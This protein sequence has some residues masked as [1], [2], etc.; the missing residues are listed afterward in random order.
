[1]LGLLGLMGLVAA[2][3]ALDAMLGGAGDED[4]P[5]A[6]PEDGAPD[7]AEAFDRDPALTDASLIPNGYG[8]AA[9]QPV[10]DPAEAGMPTS[11]DRP[12]AAEAA[13]EREGT[14]GD[15]RLNGAGG[16]DTL[17]GLDGRDTLEGWDGDDT[18]AGGRGDDSLNGGSGHDRLL[19]GAGQDVLVGGSGDDSLTGGGGNDELDG[20]EGNDLLVGGAGD[21]TLN[22]G[23][24]DDRLYAGTGG[25]LTGG[26]GADEFVLGPDGRV[27]VTD[28]DAGADR[29]VLAYDA[30][31]LPAPVVTVEAA[32]MDAVIRLNGAEVA[33][34]T[35]GAGM[36][37]GDVLLRAV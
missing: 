22:G 24:G 19:G 11:D 12:D 28:F 37:A 32:G 36:Q 15:D 14:G 17:A 27:T 26:A 5:D 9:P 16:D 18:L 8:D 1:M 23:A 35:G 13:V 25:Y 2:G 7:E 20:G 4:G 21:D 29:I 6:A 33:V 10:I 34:V 31:A 30:A 3:I